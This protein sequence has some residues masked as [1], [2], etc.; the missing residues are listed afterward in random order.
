MRRHVYGQ[1]DKTDRDIRR[2]RQIKGGTEK[3]NTE[4][5]RQRMTETDRNRQSQRQKQRR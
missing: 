4:K 5:G 2:Q 1:V 3:A